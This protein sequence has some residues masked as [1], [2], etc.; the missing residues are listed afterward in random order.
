MQVPDTV[1]SADAVL[2]MPVGNL[3]KDVAMNADELFEAG[4]RAIEQG[5]QSEAQQMFAQVLETDPTHTQA[6]YLQGCILSEAGQYAEAIP[7]Y[8]ECLRHSGEEAG[9]PLFNLGYACQAVG[10]VRNELLAFQRAVQ[11][12]PTMTDAWINIGR[13]LD[14]MGNHETAVECYDTALSIQPQ[15]AMALANRGN[16]LKS[17]ERYPEALTSYEKAL[18]EDPEDIAARTGRAVCLFHTGDPATGLRLLDEVIA[19]AGH[20]VAKFEKSVLLVLSEQYV[21]ALTLLE[22]ILE[23]GFADREIHNNRGECL[24]KLNRTEEALAAFEESLAV[25]AAFT[26]A[27]FGKARLLVNLDRVEDARSVTE[28][29]IS[30]ADEQEKQEDHIRALA[31]ICGIQL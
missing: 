11:A 16:S 17:L 21:E 23:D 28:K 20:V 27:L 5:N 15:D 24:V 25:D 1:S 8:E 22:E 31:S 3:Q 10:D 19:A 6:L 30:V 26:G 12:D 29:L 18:E 9:H 13:L 14:D 4:M 7:V 2:L